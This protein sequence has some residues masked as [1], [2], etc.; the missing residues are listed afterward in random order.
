MKFIFFCLLFCEIPLCRKIEKYRE[1]SF[2]KA[3]DEIL[4][5]RNSRVAGTFNSASATQSDFLKQE[6]S[7]AVGAHGNEYP[8]QKA[9]QNFAF[10]Y[11]QKSSWMQ[12]LPSSD[13]MVK[14]SYI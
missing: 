4:A 8:F 12:N 13:A 1:D 11:T 3:S 14:Y 2:L 10:D 5:H 9:C 6:Y 7:E